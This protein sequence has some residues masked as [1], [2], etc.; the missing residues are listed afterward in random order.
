MGLGWRQGRVGGGGPQSAWFGAARGCAGW[1]TGWHSRPWART[2]GGGENHLERGRERWVCSRIFIGI[3]L[4]A[5]YDRMI[6]KG[7]LTE[8]YKERPAHR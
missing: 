2:S 4:S 1:L 5:M 7:R 8:L 3:G 6:F